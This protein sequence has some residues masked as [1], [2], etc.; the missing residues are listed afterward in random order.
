MDA[1]LEAPLPIGTSTYAQVDSLLT[2]PTDDDADSTSMVKV[3]KDGS[4]TES[5]SVVC[6]LA[7]SN[8]LDNDIAKNDGEGEGEEFCVLSDK[9]DG[10]PSRQSSLLRHVVIGS[11]LVGDTSGLNNDAIDYN[12]QRF[13]KSYGTR[14]DWSDSEKATKDTTN[15]N[16]FTDDD[17]DDLYHAITAVRTLV[18]EYWHYIVCSTKRAS[19]AIRNT[20]ST[21]M[22]LLPTTCS[23]IFSRVVYCT[24]NVK[25]KLDLSDTSLVI[26]GLAGAVVGKL[27]TN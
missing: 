11:E 15:K 20:C 26:A 12:I 1:Y 2:I 9:G 22:Y 23:R 21:Q 16:E 14:V 17:E 13:L 27:R 5:G 25:K 4:Q 19:I 6:C 18:E 10:S 7:G 24:Y 3:E 8:L